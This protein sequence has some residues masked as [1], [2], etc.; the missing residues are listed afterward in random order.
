MAANFQTVSAALISD[1]TDRRI[2]NLL[3]N[4]VAGWS[5]IP[6]KKVDWSGDVAILVCRAERNGSIV[7]VLGN[8]EPAAGQQ[9]FIRLTIQAKRVLGRCE[10]DLFTMVSAD[11][12]KGSVAIEPADE[13]EGLLNDIPKK[14][15]FYA[16]QGGGGLQN[17][18]GLTVAGSMIGLIWQ[19]SNAITTYGYRGRFIDIIATAPQAINLARFIRLDTYAQVG[20]DQLITALDSRNITVAANIDTSTLPVGVPCGVML[21]GAASQAFVPSLITGDNTTGNPVISVPVGTA[22]AVPVGALVG[23][24]TGFIANLTQP[25]HFGN[26]RSTG[27]TVPMMTRLRSNFRVVNNTNALGGD[28]LSSIEYT[29]LQA[30]IRTRSGQGTE[31]Y[32]MSFSTMVAYPD[33]LTGT[34]DA[35]VRINVQDGSKKQDAQAPAVKGNDAFMSSYAVGGIPINCAVDCPDGIAIAMNYD[36]WGRSFKGKQEGMWAGQAGPGTTPLVKLPGLTAWGATRAMFPEQYAVTPL[37]QG[38]L[39]GIADP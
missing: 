13:I 15:T 32:W 39:L 12:A 11:D 20:A 35:N 6:V 19:R 33:S 21:V 10:I 29:K 34:A 3:Q 25:L 23:D 37:A 9:G 5:K 16:F 2:Y 14:M 26:D 7:S 30:D 27:A 1:R 36:G 24:L 28:V 18:A 4:D 31:A 8:V 38:I 22:G 17:V